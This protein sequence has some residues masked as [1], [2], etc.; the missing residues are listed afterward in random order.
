[1][2]VPSDAVVREPISGRFR[3]SVV[4][5]LAVAITA[6]LASGSAGGLGHIGYDRGLG[7]VQVG[8]AIRRILPE[9]ALIL[10]PPELSWLRALT[11]RSVVADCKATPFGKA[12]WQEYWVRIRALGGPC[13]HQGSDFEHLQITDL[14]GLEETYGGTH[15][16]LF[17]DDPKMDYAR[18]HW[19]L[20]YEAPPPAD[21]SIRQG[22]V[23]FDL[24]PLR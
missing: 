8:L 7:T 18:R 11:Q 21:G 22:L 23:L 16:L 10:A 19:T 12:E 14:D 4:A 2:T 20:L 24:T 9:S 15:V 13:H 1:M 5:A 6:T 17:T 3:R